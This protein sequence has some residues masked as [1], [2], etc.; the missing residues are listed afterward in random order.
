MKTIWSSVIAIAASALMAATAAA[1]IQSWDKQ[2]NNTGR[3]KLL[4]PFGNAAVLDQET[5]LVWE[6]SPA[7]TQHKW[8]TR[9]PATAH[10]IC[11]VKIVGNRLGWRLPTIQELAS[12]A[13]PTQFQPPLPPGHPFILTAAQ[14]IGQFWSATTAATDPDSPNSAWFVDFGLLDPN[15]IVLYGSGDKSTLRFVWCVRGGSGIDPQ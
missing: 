3:F 2:I 8:S 15:S 4:S 11:D 14:Q 10:I 12:L 13:D 5:G 6:R 1:Q 9:P 7:T